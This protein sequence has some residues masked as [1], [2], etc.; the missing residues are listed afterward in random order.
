MLVLFIVAETIQF[1]E[2]MRVLRSNEPLLPLCSISIILYCLTP[3][4]S[5]LEIKRALDLDLVPYI[6]I[7]NKPSERSL[8][9]IFTRSTHW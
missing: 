9:V 4:E 6:Y 1:A 5:E 7:I 8:Q 2:I 3:D